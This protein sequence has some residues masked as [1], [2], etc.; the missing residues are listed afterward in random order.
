MLFAKQIIDCLKQQRVRAA[1]EQEDRGRPEDDQEPGENGG[2][3]RF[4]Y[5]YTVRKIN[6]AIDMQISKVTREIKDS[7]LNR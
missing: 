4:F 6:V 5:S 7:M 1:G 2:I 3:E